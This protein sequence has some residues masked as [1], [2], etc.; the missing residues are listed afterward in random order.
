VQHLESEF[1]MFVYNLY[2]MWWEP[3]AEYDPCILYRVTAE[4]IESR[5]S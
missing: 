5:L 1:G 3:T 2:E 4:L